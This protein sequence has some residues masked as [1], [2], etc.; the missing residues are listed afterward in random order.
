MQIQKVNGTS[1]Y[2]KCEAWTVVDCLVELIVGP[3]LGANTVSTIVGYAAQRTLVF[4]ELDKRLIDRPD[5]SF[6]IAKAEED[7]REGVLV[8]TDDFSQGAVADAI[9]CSCCCYNPPES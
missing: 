5:N 1:S 6:P 9:I 4:P 8:A 2:N 7:K 3:V